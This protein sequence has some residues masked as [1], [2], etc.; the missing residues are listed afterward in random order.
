GNLVI[1]ENLRYRKRI[2]FSCVAPTVAEGLEKLPAE[3]TVNNYVCIL[4][5]NKIRNGYAVYYSSYNG[6][7][8]FSENDKTLSDA[9]HKMWLYLKKEGLL[10]D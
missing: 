10:N 7:E 8:G 5:I 6:K 1:P 3:I 9:V 2:V 4:Y